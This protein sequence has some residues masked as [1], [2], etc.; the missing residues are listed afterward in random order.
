M[1]GQTQ[2]ERGGSVRAGVRYEHVAKF[3][4]SFTLK[5]LSDPKTMR[6]EVISADKEKSSLSEKSTR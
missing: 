4:I 5:F 3:T 1:T 2:A 6:S